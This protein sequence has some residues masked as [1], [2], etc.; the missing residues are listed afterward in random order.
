MYKYVRPL[1][2]KMNE[3]RA[4]NLVVNLASTKL[5]R[6]LSRNY[7]PGV[8][9]LP[10]D[11]LG[12]QVQ[13]PV[14]L[15]PGL[16]KD[17]RALET[18]ANFGFGFTEVGTVTA[19]KNEGNEKPRVWRIKEEEAIVN[20]MGFPSVGYRDFY[21]NLIKPRMNHLMVGVSISGNDDC[22][23][24]VEKFYPLYA[25]NDIFYLVINTSSPSVKNLR[26]IE[27]D[28]D[29]LIELIDNVVTARDVLSSTYTGKPMPIALKISPDLTR[30]Q[31]EKTAEIAKDYGVDAVIVNNTTVHRPQ[32]LNKKVYSFAGGLSGKPI[33]SI[34]ENSVNIVAKTLQGWPVQVIGVGG[35]SNA[36]DAWR[37]FLAG[38]DAIQICTSLV[39][40]GPTI[41]RD[42]VT[43]LQERA[44]T[45]HESAYWKDGY[46]KFSFTKAVE[47]AR[48]QETDWRNVL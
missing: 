43:G 5:A 20:N 25:T 32:N 8:P 44:S 38:A 22:I 42:I 15:A 23:K 14:G 46:T 37:L 13:N 3:E 27:V 33:L 7:Y 9:D 12:K 21:L 35:V 28:D 16:D 17:A 24:A 30:Y 36:D 47:I 34:T 4:N 40:H 26:Q 6:T 1:L 31:M 10:I 48:E 41:V 19:K 11:L 2:F 39:Y 29:Q 18:F 45:Y